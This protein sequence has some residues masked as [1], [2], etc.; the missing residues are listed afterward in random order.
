M[1]ALT[2]SV[3]TLEDEIKYTKVSKGT[4][5]TLSKDNRDIFD[6]Y[7][8]LTTVNNIVLVTPE[9]N[10]TVE[11]DSYLITLV[12]VGDEIQP[13]YKFTNLSETQYVLEEENMVVKDGMIYKVKTKPVENRVVVSVEPG[14]TVVDV[15]TNETFEVIAINESQLVLKEMISGV[16]E[17]NDSSNDWDNKYQYLEV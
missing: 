15:N 3:V 17:I 1:N 9:W 6:K 12:I 7:V 16:F 14:D 8:V 13:Q 10:E 2:K 5:I 4:V 11:D